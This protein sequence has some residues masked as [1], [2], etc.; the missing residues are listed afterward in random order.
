MQ[1]VQ[2]GT[3]AVRLGKVAVIGLGADGPAVAQVV[4][5]D[6]HDALPGQILR[7]RL[8]PVDELHHAVGQLQHRPH[9]PLRDAAKAVQGAPRHGG[10]KGKVD[11]LTHEKGASFLRYSALSLRRQAVQMQ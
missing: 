8:V 9:L 2:H 6:H 5:A 1:I 11:E 3:V 10:G 4:V 7:Q